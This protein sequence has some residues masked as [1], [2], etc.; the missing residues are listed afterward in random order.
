[1][2]GQQVG[3]YKI[4]KQIGEEAMGMVYLGEHQILKQ[5]VAVKALDPKLV[6]ADGMKERFER[7]AQTLARL[8]H[9]NVI[10]LL[11]F[12]SLPEG[13][14]IVLEFA[15]G[16]TLE[17]KVQKN[18]PVPI[19]QAVSW[20]IQVLRALQHA[21]SLEVIH[22]DLKPA[23]VL[24]TADGVP[25]V[26]DFGLAKVADAPV[27]TMQGLTLG[28]PYYMSVEQLLGKNLDAR[29]DVY[30]AGVTLYE[31]TTGK[32]PFD[33]PE[34]KKLVLKI[35]RQDPPPP[36][37]LVP[38]FPPELEKV[39]LKA[40]TKDPAKRYQSAEEMAQA[41]EA[42]GG[43]GAAPPGTAPA[44]E[45]GAAASPPASAPAAATPATTSPATTP[46]RP[47]TAKLAPSPE[48]A[49]TATAAA[50]PPAPAAEPPPSPPKPAEA[51][52]TARTAIMSP[53][54]ITGLCVLMGSAGLGI[55]VQV[56]D[57]EQKLLVALS[58]GMGVPVGLVLAAVAVLRSFS[59]RP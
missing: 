37:K 58:L 40:L 49:A 55:A 24:V 46:P 20:M 14:F 50:A 2:I 8:N 29:S 26:L 43:A 42:L 13:C 25:K 22:R 54:L 48:L 45:A 51:P 28:T 36:S 23:N 34:E 32:L 47:G 4:V 33:D 52:A 1:V 38:S 17:E 12:H 44:A 53:L 30:S 7:E 5:K 15:E 59:T 19:P 9:P 11:N 57:P 35:A 18:G 39:I 31:I 21:H 10:R 27:L 56:V 3:D 6:T 16:E 41:L